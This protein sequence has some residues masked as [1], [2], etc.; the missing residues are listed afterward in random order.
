MQPGWITA[1]TRRLVEREF[2][3]EHWDVVHGL[4]A[5]KCATNLPLLGDAPREAIERIQFAVVKL[6][7]G[8]FEELERHIAIANIDWRDTLVAAGFGHSIRAH[9]SWF[10]ERMGA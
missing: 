8:K 4:L 1:D 3:C 10:N 9:R 2:A 7:N 6:C 5:N